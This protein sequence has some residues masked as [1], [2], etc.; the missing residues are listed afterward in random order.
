MNVRIKYRTF[1]LKISF[2]LKRITDILRRLSR[3]V[4]EYSMTLLDRWYF[5]L[6]LIKV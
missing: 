1:S 5:L 2:D 3:R 4:K 6:H